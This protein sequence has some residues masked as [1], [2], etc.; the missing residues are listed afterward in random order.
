[1]KTTDARFRPHLTASTAIALTLLASPLA[2]QQMGME[3]GTPQAGALPGGVSPGVQSSGKDD[4]RFDFHGFF[5]MPL[6]VGF[7][8]RENPAPG[9]S[10]TTWHAPPLVPGE[11]GSSAFTN[12][13]QR[14][15]TQLNFSYG[16]T[17]VRGTVIIAA[18]TATSAAGFY[19][20]PDHIGIQDAFVSFDLPSGDKAHYV[21]HVGVFNNRY[22]ATGEFDEGYYATPLMARV[23]GAG[24]T[25]GARWVLSEKVHAQGEAGLMGT[26][27]KPVL[28]TIPEGWNGFADPNIGST[29]AA[30]GHL[31]VSYDSLLHVAGHYFHTFAKDD[32]ASVQQQPDARMSVYGGDVRLTMG[33]W[34]HFYFGVSMADAQNIQSLGGVVRYLNTQNGPDLIRNYL[35]QNSDGTGKLTT[36]GGQ[37]DFSLAAALLHP[38]PFSGN[39]PDLRLSVFGMQ[40]SASDNGRSNRR[41][42]IDR[43]NVC[44]KTCNKF[45]GELTYKPLS[46]FAMAMRGDQVN[47]DTTDQAE[48]FTVVSPRLIFSSDW[49]SQD[50]IALQYSR[51]FYGS[52]VLVRSPGYDPRDLTYARPD[53]QTLSLHATMWW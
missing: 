40:T 39:A 15:W 30:H 36:F 41:P 6:W 24:T 3:P 51:Y 7:G 17:Q 44:N 34:G 32:Q 26:I 42:P 11:M 38:Q 22:G 37:Y 31:G 14:P 52:Q 33:P 13:L 19:N 18:Q 43:F 25:F 20:P 46:W 9:Q 21:A 29:Y 16:T 27:D 49:N 1:M 28:G 8:Q 50:Q 45:G 53:E 12:V 4:W 48:S 47:L 5:S 23:Q 2:A 35:G 10:S